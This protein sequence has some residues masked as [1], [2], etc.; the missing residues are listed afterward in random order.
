MKHRGTLVVALAL[1]GSA[2]AVEAGKGPKPPYCD[3]RCAVWRPC[4]K[5]CR[6]A[7][8]RVTTCGQY[9]LCKPPDPIVLDPEDPPPPPPCPNG[10]ERCSKD[11]RS[12][13]PAVPGFTVRAVSA[14]GLRL[15]FDARPQGVADGSGVVW[16]FPRGL[17][18][19]GRMV[20][21][22]FR[23]PGRYRVTLEVTESVCNTPQS[24]TETIDVP[25]VLD[26]PA[27][28]PN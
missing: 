8:E 5:L 17:E 6:Q 22:Q 13:C 1:L 18:A 3:D 24:R 27:L 26:F 23:A 15:R 10:G 9:G 14:E 28:L 4:N 11:G 7:D 21:H 20:V 12:Y 16:T 19:E 2:G 25:P